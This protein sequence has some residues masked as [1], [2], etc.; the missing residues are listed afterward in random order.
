MKKAAVL[1]I[2]FF[3]ALRAPDNE[4]GVLLVS[5]T[6]SRYLQHL[7]EAVSTGYVVSLI[8]VSVCAG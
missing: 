2:P 1:S 5:F 8:S 7:T 6:V 3:K 4:H